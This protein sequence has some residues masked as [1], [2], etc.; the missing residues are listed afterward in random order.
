MPSKHKLSK[1]EESPEESQEEESSEGVEYYDEEDYGSESEEVA[2]T[3]KDREVQKEHLINYESDESD[4][5]DDSE[6]DLGVNLT[7]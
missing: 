7:K 3:G 5:D 4:E 1:K 6:G 2:A